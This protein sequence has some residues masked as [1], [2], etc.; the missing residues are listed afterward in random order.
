MASFRGFF[1]SWRLLARIAPKLRLPYVVRLA[2]VLSLAASP[3]LAA[4]S[5]S[6]ANDAD[7][8][9]LLKGIEQRYNNAKS[10]EVTFSEAYSVHGRPRQEE[11]GKL[12]LRKPGR[13]RWDYTAPAGKLFISNGKDVYLYTPNTR[14]VER[15]PLKESDDMRAP[16]AFLLGKLDFR[17]EFRDFH[18]K[19]E[20]SDYSL[21][22]LAKTDQLPY[23]QI[24]MLVT[25]DYAIRKL[26]VTGTDASV[27]TFRFDGEK[28]NPA[29]NNAV[30]KFEM[31]A[32]ARFASED[33]N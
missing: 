21:T 33:E 15:M 19:A 8:T 5:L 20:G 2:L 23:E 31:P 3:F 24:E 26:V 11:S 30:F 28:L 4:P 29:V 25:P 6:A 16:L 1:C 17:K 18:W 13:M 9:R 14:L 27:L 7:L 22:A 12:T 32:G 10:L